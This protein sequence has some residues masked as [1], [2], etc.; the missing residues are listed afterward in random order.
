MAVPNNFLKRKKKISVTLFCVFRKVPAGVEVDLFQ[1][2]SC[3]VRFSLTIAC[4]AAVFDFVVSV[5]PLSL[6]R[7]WLHH[8][9]SHVYVS[10][11]FTPMHQPSLWS[12]L[13]GIWFSLIHYPARELLV[14]TCY[15]SSAFEILTAKKLNINLLV[16]FWV[17]CKMRYSGTSQGC[18]RVGFY[19]NSRAVFSAVVSLHTALLYSARQRGKSEDH[20]HRGVK[21]KWGNI[22]GKTQDSSQAAIMSGIPYL[23]TKKWQHKKKILI[24]GCQGGNWHWLSINTKS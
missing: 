4:L 19:G 3:A 22:S 17:N 7:L 12:P 10:I 15:I 18:T 21:R 13:G 1:V 16:F 23:I 6:K 14:S 24:V 11:L 2:W 20:S 9:L 5:N 8:L